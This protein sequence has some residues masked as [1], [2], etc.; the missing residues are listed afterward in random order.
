M[1]YK[2]IQDIGRPSEMV[3]FFSVKLEEYGQ[4]IICQVSCDEI[5]GTLQEAVIDP[6]IPSHMFV[7][8]KKVETF[9]PPV[10]T[11]PVIQAKSSRLSEADEFADNSLE[12]EDFLAAES[13]GFKPI[14]NF[15]AVDNTT[16]TNHS[17]KHAVHR[18]ASCPAPKSDIRVATSPA[19]RRITKSTA[20]ENQER[21]CKHI[22]KDKSKYA[23]FLMYFNL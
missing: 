3:K 9:R 5:A 14:S 6:G 18:K 1:L 13:E 12:V 17:K 10:T 19:N 2:H 23:Q 16:N 22:C 4:K 21:D 15:Q 7:S 11:A 8:C 20:P